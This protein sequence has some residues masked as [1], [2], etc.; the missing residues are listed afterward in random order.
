M[1]EGFIIQDTL[2]QKAIIRQDTIKQLPDSSA[3]KNEVT[4]DPPLAAKVVH[5]QPVEKF[6]VTDT[7]SSCRRN[8][9]A[10]VTFNDSTNIVTR[11]DE[12]LLQNFPFVFTGINRKIREE[13]KADLVKH[14][15]IH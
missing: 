14:R 8:S 12:S 10:D 1:M 7:T 2:K 3:H 15:V 6:Q 11:I 4:R 13:T 9:I 5:F